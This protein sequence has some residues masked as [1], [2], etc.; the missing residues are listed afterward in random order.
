MKIVH[1]IGSIDP[2]GGGPPQVVVRLAAAQS[3]LGHEAHI[4]TYGSSDSFANDR[5]KRQVARIPGISNVT[6][7]TLNAPTWHERLFSSEAEALLRNMLPGSDW[8]HLHGVW[9]RSLHKAAAVAKQLE[10]PYCFRPAGML[11]PWSLRQKR[12][13]KRVAMA[14]EVRKSLDAA[15]FIHALN[16]SEADLIGLLGLQ[17]PCVVLPNGIFFEEIEP[18]PVRGTFVARWPEL[19]D[20]PFVLF[21]ARLHYKKGLDLLAKAWAEVAS[22]VPDAHL[23][24]A[25]PDEGAKLDFETAIDRAQL[26]HRVHV[27]GP[28][29]DADKFAALVDARCFCLPSRQE[30]FSVAVL[31][32]MACGVPVIIS[33]ACHF[34]EAAEAGAAKVVNLED[35]RS[36][37]QALTEILK[38]SERAN[39]MGRSGRELISRDY[40]WPAI[41]QRVIDA[42]LNVK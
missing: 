25:G 40:T 42:Y 38:N 26:T 14:V 15:S 19:R 6:I 27:V 18:L 7:H 31:E 8:L 24:V 11:D 3:N 29:Y 39:E 10:I 33:E 23:V 22:R 1:V 9:E 37:P 5:I 17:S 4:V 20:R 13:K 2:I 32:A 16:S 34:P 21:L 36:L 12:W 28:L 30:G 41:A 35:V